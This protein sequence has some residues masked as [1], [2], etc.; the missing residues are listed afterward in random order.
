MA[1]T[2]DSTHAANAKPQEF[3]ISG[4]NLGFGDRPMVGVVL[5]NGK[6][7][8]WEIWQVLDHLHRFTRK[9]Q[10]HVL[11][12]LPFS[13]QYDTLSDLDRNAILNALHA[14]AA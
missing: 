5:E 9:A 3:R 13:L 11:G 7:A 4:D 2:N 14:E 6:P 1:M 12:L 8:A 10:A